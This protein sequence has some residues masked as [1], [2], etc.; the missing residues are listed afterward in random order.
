MISKENGIKRNPLMGGSTKILT[1]FNYFDTTPYPLG[2]KS[3]V[4]IRKIITRKLGNDVCDFITKHMQ[5]LELFDVFLFDS[6]RKEDI[7]TSHKSHYKSVINLSSANDYRRINKFFETVNQKLPEGGRFINS[8]VTREKRKERFLKKYPKPLN[9][10]LYFFDFMIHRVLPKVKITKKLYFSITKGK[11]RVLT[12]AEVFGRLYACGFD[13]VDE[14]LIGD[15]LYFVAE[16][17][18]APAFDTN[19]TYGPLISLKRVGKNGKAIDVYKFRTMHPYA[20]YL[21]KYVFEKNNLR[22]GGKLNNDF[23]ISNVGSMF[24]K[25]W[26]DELPMILNFLKGDLKLIGG[27]PLSKHYFS[28]YTKELQE[29]RI[30]FKPGLIP[31]FYAD[32]PETLEDIIASE[33]KYL[34]AYEKNPLTTDIHYCYK[35]FKNIVF[36][37]KRSF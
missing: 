14:Q 32:M 24:R 36:R 4:A 12:K 30:K 37:G 2:I 17:K 29:K 22:K 7:S 33:M 18:D 25:Y 31:P 10:L 11:G 9:H 19:P 3:K 20:E 6:I 35:I 16:K 8:F 27:R 5:G 23:R 28:L 34:E 1:D 13:L 21:Q 15:K 26:I